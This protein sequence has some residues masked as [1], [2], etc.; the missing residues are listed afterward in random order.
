[1]DDR[2]AADRL[3]GVELNVPRSAL[4]ETEEDEEFYYVDLIGCWAVSESGEDLGTVTAVH[5]F[6]AG[7][8]I[9]VDGTLYRF[10]K[11]EVPV[12]DLDDNRLVI[13]D[14]AVAAKEEER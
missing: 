12:V 14:E 7:A 3:K 11:E 2:D 6:G 1:M 4:P 8:V 13:A 5:D 10:T 9:E